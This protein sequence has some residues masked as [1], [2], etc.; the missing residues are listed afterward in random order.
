MGKE[1]AEKVSTLLDKYY[2]VKLSLKG[3]AQV[4]PNKV[5]PRPK[6]TYLCY[7]FEDQFKIS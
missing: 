4:S 1:G 6:L 7:L 2:K 3:G 5:D